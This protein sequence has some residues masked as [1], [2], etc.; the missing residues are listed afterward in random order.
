MERTIPLTEAGHRLRLSYNQILR[1]VMVGEL[2]GEQIDG[3]WQV[4]A[5]QV[6]RLQKPGDVSSDAVS[7]A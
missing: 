1:R 5:D 3:R 2:R 4:D 7:A 6:E